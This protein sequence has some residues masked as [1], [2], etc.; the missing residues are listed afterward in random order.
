V[1]AVSTSHSL[2]IVGVISLAV[3]V[4]GNYVQIV[5]GLR[6]ATE[7]TRVALRGIVR[8]LT[9]ADLADGD[10]EARWQPGPA[11]LELQAAEFPRPERTLGLRPRPGARLVPVIDRILLVLLVVLVVIVL[12][13]LLT[14]TR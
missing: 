10:V 3:Y 1:L 6:Q 4:V 8:W 7:E 13:L 9:G 2:E 11:L 5:G 12:V 14:R